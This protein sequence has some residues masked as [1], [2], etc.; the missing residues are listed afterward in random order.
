MEKLDLIKTL[1]KYYKAKTAPEILEIAEGK[2]VTIE[3]KGEPAEKEFLEKT[4]T[5]YPVAYGIKKIY[6]ENGKDFGVPKLQGLWWVNSDKP[7]LQ[8]PKSE[9]FWKLM[10]RVPDFVTTEM[11][12][13]V[14]E[15]VFTKKKL[16]LAKNVLLENFTEGK[17]I[18][19]LHIGSYATES[20]TLKR[21]DDF[22]QENG[23]TKTGKHHEIYL[24]DP[25]KTK[26]DKLQTILR[27]PVKL[28]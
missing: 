12:A 22:V 11:H 3:G 16:L 26:S 27:Q 13:K 23:L 1:G 2:F 6:K 10:I 7:A 4:A 19:M 25:N 28:R 8:V 5:L 15:E 20:I 9:W 17:S 18:Q 21:M 24:S 14:V